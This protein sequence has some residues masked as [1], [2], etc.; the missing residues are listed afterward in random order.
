M[1]KLSKKE[2]EFL[3]DIEAN[4]PEPWATMA[5]NAILFDNRETLRDLKKIINKQKSK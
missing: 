3:E 2:K 1:K 5:S 4:K